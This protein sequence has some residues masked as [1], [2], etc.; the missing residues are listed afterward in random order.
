MCGLQLTMI[1]QDPP[2]SYPEYVPQKGCEAEKIVFREAA[3]WTAGFF[4]GSIYLLL[5]RTI[6]LPNSL[7]VSGAPVVHVR[8]QLHRLG[9]TWSEPLHAMAHRTD[10]HDLS[11]MLQPSMRSR[12]ELLHDT[13]ALDT[14]VRAAHFLHS[15][16]SPTVGAIRFWTT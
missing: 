13:A 1:C 3:F 12:W 9:Q 16:Y 4:P 11:F 15:R 8:D 7:G 14:L 5:E 2:T 10:T 6:K